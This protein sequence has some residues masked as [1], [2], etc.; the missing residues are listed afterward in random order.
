MSIECEQGVEG[1]TKNFGV[2]VHRD[3][4]VTY[5]NVEDGVDVD[6]FRPGDGTKLQRICLTT[7]RYVVLLANC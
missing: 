4:Y 1:N 5:A 3:S 7:A 6:F 2:F